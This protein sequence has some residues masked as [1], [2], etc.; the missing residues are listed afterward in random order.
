[1]KINHKVMGGSLLVSGTC[2]GAGAIALPINLI[3]WGSVG[4]LTILSVTW[5]VMACAGMLVYEANLSFPEG[6]N[7]TKM[8][9]VIF[10]DGVAIIVV[11]MFLGLLYALLAAYITGG[12][13]L[14]YS[15][16]VSS[17]KSV[18]PISASLWAL[19]GI[20][21]ITLGVAWL[22]YINR[23]FMALLIGS[24]LCFAFITM[25]HI[26]LVQVW[27]I[28][29]HRGID[30]ISIVMTA[31]GYQVIVPSLRSY[32]GQ[33]SKKMTA[34]IGLGTLVP[35]FVY[36]IW[37]MIVYG[38]IPYQ[39]DLGLLRL[40]SMS[41]ASLQLPLVLA[42][43]HKGHMLIGLIDLFMFAAI[44]SS[45]I[46]LALSL[47][48][49]M[50]DLLRRYDIVLSQLVL[51]LLT[52]LPPFVFSL[53]YPG[54][55]SLALKYAGFF[56]ACINLLLPAA[57]VMRLRYGRVSGVKPQGYKV[58]GGWGPVVMVMAYG[59]S[60]IVIGLF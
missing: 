37:C 49:F 40:S 56:V 24:Y 3:G 16:L 39:G 2:I 5:L 38:V 15:Q 14:V 1:M 32:M 43:L 12:S 41:N 46:G 7:L 36:L 28:P 60:V 54:G 31:F 55:F 44:V 27:S 59:F 23:F 9:E 8:T 6:T 26:E 45:F 13:F 53:L 17:A 21:V 33:S 25:P 52:I 10:G 22:D 4:A 18:S 57:M 34:V 48:D 20:I 29:Y 11:A 47:C 35:L 58:P 42:R 51:A 30:A 19:I 50:R